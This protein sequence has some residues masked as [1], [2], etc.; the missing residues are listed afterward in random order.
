MQT[1]ETRGMY[2]MK[3]WMILF[4]LFILYAINFIDK[5]MIGVSSV[6]IMKEFGLTYAQ[7]GLVGSSF[8]W[9]FFI[10][11]FIGGALSDR[12]GPKKMLAYMAIIW[13]FAQFI[14]ILS[15]SVLVLLMSRLLLGIGEGPTLPVAINQINRWFPQPQRGM[16]TYVITLGAI[17]GSVC[18][19]IMVTV[20]SSYGWRVAFIVTSLAS[21]IWLVLWLIVSKGKEPHFP[22]KTAGEKNHEKL[23]WDQWWAAVRS[24]SFLFPALALFATNWTV[25]FELSFL[26]NYFTEVKGLTSKELG[27]VMAIAG[28]GGALVGI[29]L[30]LLSDLIFK[31]TGKYKTSRVLF[32]SCGIIVAGLG[33]ASITLAHSTGMMILGYGLESAFLALLIANVPQIIMTAMPSRPGTIVG[34][35]LGLGG[36]AGIIGPIVTGKIIESTGASVSVGFGNALL[37]IAILCTIAGLLLALFTKPD[38]LHLI[39]G[40]SD[41]NNDAE[42][43]SIN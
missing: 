38:S 21:L 28:L 35:A 41:I 30:T 42:K 15:S 23:H 37:V 18:F 22:S 16:A 13:A 19:P 29:P 8:Y 17:L 33:F 34:L 6:L 20:V 40:K 1:N 26:P 24:P 12:I 25:S 9:L 4:L 5:G 43:I 2:T 3:K 32:S 39:K 27:T 10:M 31:K 14:P 11:S 7:W 36:T